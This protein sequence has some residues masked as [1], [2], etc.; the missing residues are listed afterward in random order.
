VVV[1]REDAF[2][3]DAMAFPRGALGAAV[4]QHRLKAV[5]RGGKLGLGRRLRLD[6]KS[7]V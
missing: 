4:E 7:V 3:G 1:A 5:D 6:R 2:L